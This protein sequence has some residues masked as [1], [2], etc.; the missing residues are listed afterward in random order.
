MIDLDDTL[1]SNNM[2]TFIPAYLE[3]LGSQL[4]NYVE[5]ETF[6]STLLTSTEKMLKIDQPY[7]TLK[8]KFESEFN[9]RLGFDFQDIRQPIEDFYTNHFDRVGKNLHPSRQVTYPTNKKTVE[10][11]KR[12]KT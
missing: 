1:I 10:N 7:V 11:K 12:I 9:T 5:P 2:E 8:N 4:A 3:A 6:I